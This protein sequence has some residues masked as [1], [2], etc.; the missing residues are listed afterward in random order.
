MSACGRR[1]VPDDEDHPEVDRNFI[2]ALA[3]AGSVSAARRSSRLAPVLEKYAGRLHSVVLA[4]LTC[5]MFPE[6]EARRLWEGVLR[7]RERL[8]KRL[9][10]KV[11]VEV[12]ALD[13]FMNAEE[14]FKNPLLI[15]ENTFRR[16]RSNILRDGLTG[17]Y[18]FRYYRMRIGEMV[19]AAKRYRQLFSLLLFDIDD[20]KAYNDAYGH[21]EGDRVLRTVA[22]LGSECLRHSDVF[23]RYGGEEFVV[24][25][26]NTAKRNA[27][28]AAEKLRER[29]AV[30]PFRRKVT[31]SGGIATFLTDTEKDAEDLFRC[32][33]Q[34]LYRAKAE[35]KNR[36]CLYAVE[37]RHYP[38]ISLLKER[39]KVRVLKGAAGVKG[40]KDAGLGGVCFYTDRGLDTGHLLEVELTLPGNR[41]VVFTGEAVWVANVGDSL[42]ECGI[43]FVKIGRKPLEHLKEYLERF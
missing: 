29:I 21:Q 11:R 2:A 34:A 9:G 42:F 18:N 30:H 23:V 1:C 4:K 40:V 19:N 33:D 31:V 13:Y 35:G 38:R 15:A 3:E 14:G 39:I 25:L 27:L 7:N 22:R 17:L 41:K 26:P 12:A 10:R 24:L 8:S 32:A 43:K 28:V 20:F 5:E 36:V 6:A 37:K 16:L